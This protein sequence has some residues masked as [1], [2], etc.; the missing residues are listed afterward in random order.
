MNEEVDL[1]AAQPGDERLKH[2]AQVIADAIAKQYNSRYKSKI[3]VPVPL[4]FEL[5]LAQPKYAGLACSTAGVT[6]KGNLTITAQEVKLNLTLFR[7]N[8]REFLNEVIPHEMAHLKQRWADVQ[9]MTE[10]APHGYVWQIAMREISKTPT[11]KHAMDTTK[12]VL[13]YKAHK[14]KERKVKAALKKAATK[15]AKEAA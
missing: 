2:L 15:A 8:K 14:D 1:L 7:D 11:A 4:S 3:P 12:A 9:N 13:V 6:E 10:S 5:E